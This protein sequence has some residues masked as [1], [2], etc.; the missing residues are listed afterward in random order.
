MRKFQ[1][2]GRAFALAPFALALVA[3]LALATS[4]AAAADGPRL[5]GVV[6]IN[7]ATTEELQLLPGIGESRARAVIEE[8]KRRGGFKSAE[9]LLDVKGI[10][11]A[12]L[13][14]LKP[15]VAVTGKTTARIE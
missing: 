9:E 11:D 15:F 8:R 4:P 1:A 10:G 7:T 3:A 14:R 5:T 13:Q 2:F 6:N 12:G